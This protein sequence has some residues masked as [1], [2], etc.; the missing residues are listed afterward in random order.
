VR[1]VNSNAKDAYLDDYC[2]PWLT[3]ILF[4]EECSAASKQSK[5]MQEVCWFV[6]G[7]VVWF[8]TTAMPAG[9]NV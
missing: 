6:G 8:T 9:V 5:W 7:T 4:L 2:S 3:L 1:S